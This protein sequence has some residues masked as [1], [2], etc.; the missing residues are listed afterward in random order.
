MKDSQKVWHGSMNMLSKYPWVPWVSD[1]FS[2]QSLAC[3]SSAD[4]NGCVALEQKRV[5]NLPIHVPLEVSFPASSH[6]SKMNWTIS[7]V[8]YTSPSCL[9]AQLRARVEAQRLVR[10]HVLVC[11]KRSGSGGNGCIYNA[12]GVH[13]QLAEAPD[14]AETTIPLSVF[15]H[16]HFS[17]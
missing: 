4:W 13:F 11:V 10:A 2:H 9:R 5:R 6:R 7:H 17:H 15:I 16:V 14:A 1:S 8:F 12:S 3:T